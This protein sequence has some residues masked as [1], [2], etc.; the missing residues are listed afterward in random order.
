MTFKEVK[1]RDILSCERDRLIEYPEHLKK[2]WRQLKESGDTSMLN[3][4]MEDHVVT[5]KF[6]VIV[7]AKTDTKVVLF[8]NPYDYDPDEWTNEEIE[9]YVETVEIENT[10]IRIIKPLDI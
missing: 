3:E 4:H 7:I 2:H 10:D 1:L 8:Y 6:E 9:Y 5:E